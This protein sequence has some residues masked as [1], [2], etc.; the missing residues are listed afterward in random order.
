MF[1]V[2]SCKVPRVNILYYKSLR[3]S[4]FTFHRFTFEYKDNELDSFSYLTI[5]LIPKFLKNVM[6]LKQILILCCPFSLSEHM[7]QYVLWYL[8]HN[9]NVVRLFST[10]CAIE[11]VIMPPS[12]VAVTH[13]I[14]MT[15]YGYTSDDKI[16][17]TDNSRFSM[18]TSLNGNIFRVIGPSCGEFTGHQWIPRTEASDAELWCILWSAAE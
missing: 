12:F 1:S 16:W 8:L 4:Y 13:V 15:T 11:I 5:L 9:R 3:S 14:I 7:I 18:M 10:V 2:S 6:Y 17:N